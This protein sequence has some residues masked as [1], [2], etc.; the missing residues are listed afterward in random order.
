MTHKMKKVAESIQKNAEKI[1]NEREAK[2]AAPA[3]NTT[4]KAQVVKAHIEK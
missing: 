2:T 4:Q 1:K 3:N